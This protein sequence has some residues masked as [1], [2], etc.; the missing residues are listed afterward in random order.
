MDLE[1]YIIESIAEGRMFDITVISRTIQGIQNQVTMLQN[2][3]KIT[4]KI[5]IESG[6]PLNDPA[7]Q[8]LEILKTIKLTDNMQEQV[9]SIAKS[10]EYDYAFVEYISDERW[11]H[12]VPSTGF[13]K[14]ILSTLGFELDLSAYELAKQ[15][16]PTEYGF[17]ARVEEDQKMKRSILKFTKVRDASPLTWNQWIKK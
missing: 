5:V 6:V 1:D 12:P 17:S 16:Y 14:E 9:T 7:Y 8:L 4:K 2:L 11:P 13:F 15:K 10:I 3:S